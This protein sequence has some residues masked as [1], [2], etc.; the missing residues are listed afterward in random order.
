MRKYHFGEYAVNKHFGFTGYGHF[1]FD[2]MSIYA[3]LAPMD[4]EVEVMFL[5]G[6]CIENIEVILYTFEL[7]LDQKISELSNYMMYGSVID[8]ETGMMIPIT[9]IDD[10]MQSRIIETMNEFDIF[11]H[12]MQ[13]K[14]NLSLQS[15]INELI[16]DDTDIDEVFNDMDLFLVKKG[17]KRSFIL[18]LLFDEIESIKNDFHD[19]NL[20]EFLEEDSDILDEPLHEELFTH[21]KEFD[22]KNENVNV[23][24]DSLFEEIKEYVISTQ[25]VSLSFLQRRFALNYELAKKMVDKLEE[26]GIIALI[27]GDKPLYVLMKNDE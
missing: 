26:Q 23:G 27:Q 19:E 18:D 16:S 9:D 11:R 14:F 3:Q 21:S 20:F 8:S 24:G 13:N 6:F 4:I 10:K 2:S 15:S 25:Y 1:D 12:E 17:L 5:F 22:V 7:D